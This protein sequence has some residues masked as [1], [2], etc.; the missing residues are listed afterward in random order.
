MTCHPPGGRCPA[1][2]PRAAAKQRTLTGALRGPPRAHGVSS[3]E[4]TYA[5]AGGAG[6]DTGGRRPAAAAG[7][8]TGKSTCLGLDRK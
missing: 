7:I 3:L 4:G 1:R 6:N 5:Q 2:R 8:R